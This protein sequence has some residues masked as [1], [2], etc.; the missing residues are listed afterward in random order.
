MSY[1]KL[2]ASGEVLSRL[3][4][5]KGKV[6]EGKVVGKSGDLPLLEIEDLLFAAES[7]VPLKVGAKVSL[8][9]KGI[10]GDKLHLQLLSEEELDEGFL[11]LGLKDTPEFKLAYRILKGLGVSFGRRE[12][13]LLGELILKSK[14]FSFIIEGLRALQAKLGVSASLIKLLLVL[15]S[16]F[17]LREILLKLLFY[18]DKD[19]RRFLERIIP[20]GE[21][22][23]A[24]SIKGFLLES[25]ILEGDELI[26]LLISKGGA[27]GAKLLG[28]LL[29]PR[30]L[31]LPPKE[32][33]WFIYLWFPILWD[34]GELV[35][36]S[37]KKYKSREVDKKEE[38]ERFELFLELKSLGRIRVLFYL[39]K[40]KLWLTLEAEEERVLALIRRNL[41]DLLSSLEG[42]GYDV[43][44]LSSRSMLVE[45]SFFEGEGLDIRI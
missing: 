18:G 28:W 10:F 25:G 40:G 14:D 30:V 36:S 43:G 27:D 8:W 24:E 42:Q 21:S 7:K 45:R 13:E 22:L 19:I 29:L 15:G 39:L 16:P 4:P 38:G 41:S 35:I 32:G 1:V 44:G 9:V 11:K 12:V 5:L 17:F 34:K 3:A 20:R 37:L 31:S 6:I 2:N 26:E 33:D 23:S